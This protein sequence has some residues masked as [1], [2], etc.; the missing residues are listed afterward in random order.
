M[1]PHS[2]C[3]V[4]GEVSGA[5]RSAT[6]VALGRPSMTAPPAREPRWRPR[7]RRGVL[8][9]CLAL[10]VPGPRW[11]WATCEKLS[12]PDGADVANASSTCTA[13]GIL[14]SGGSAQ[15]PGS[16]SPST[17]VKNP[18]GVHPALEGAA[19]FLPSRVAVA[20]A[21]TPATRTTLLH[22]G[23]QASSSLGTGSESRSWTPSTRHLVACR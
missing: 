20:V 13:S 15:V 10:D 2:A 9:R 23:H 17:L 8:A 22:V 14:R 12:G 21:G 1:C 7:P 6:S 16:L 3:T 4:W 18:L 19:A 5:A 11:A